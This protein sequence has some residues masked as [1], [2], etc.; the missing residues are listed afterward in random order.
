MADQEPVEVG[1]PTSAAD[2]KKSTTDSDEKAKAVK[3][4]SGKTALVKRG[5]LMVYL[6]AGRIPNALLPL[7]RA[8]IQQNSGMKKEEID[9]S[10]KESVE[11]ENVIEDMIKLTDMITVDKVVEPKVHPVP[12]CRF[13]TDGHACG[14]SQPDHL[15][16]DHKYDGDERDEQLLYVDEVDFQDK[17]S[18]FN[19]VIGGDGALETFLSEQERDVESVPDGEAVEDSPE[20]VDVAG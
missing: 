2:W 1:S 5:D 18:I 4:A 6:R 20:R 3:V 9:A 7:I 12:V 16:S 13:E 19:Y 15:G 8:S 17:M 10:I 11:D 14:K